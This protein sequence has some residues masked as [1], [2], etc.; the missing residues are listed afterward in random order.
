MRGVVMLTNRAGF[1]IQPHYGI[2]SPYI[3]S[4]H[5]KAEHMWPGGIIL[6]AYVCRVKHPGELTSKCGKLASLAVLVL[7]SI[8]SSGIS[9][10]WWRAVFTQGQLD[11][12][13]IFL[14][15]LADAEWLHF[16]K[17]YLFS[18]LIIIVYIH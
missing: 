15:E 4:H 16:N 14:A 17:M 13:L 1:C 7:P 18:F 10:Q 12:M 5:F 11:A 3:I 6:D 8:S 9:M 2:Y